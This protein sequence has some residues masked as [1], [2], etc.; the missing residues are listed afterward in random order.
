MSKEPNRANHK[1]LEQ[2]EGQ[3]WPEPDYDSYVVATIH[4]LRKKPLSD[5][6]LEDQRIMIGQ[7]IGLPHLLPI[8]LDHLVQHPFAQG[9][10]YPGDLLAAVI[11]VSDDFWAANPDLRVKALAA[12]EAALKRI[13]KVETAPELKGELLQAKTRLG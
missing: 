3:V 11:R 9:D 7:G 4:R 12:V 5:F 13:R 8:V 10:F 6:T 2:L 1:T